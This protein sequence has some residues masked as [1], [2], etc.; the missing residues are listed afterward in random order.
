[1]RRGC[2]EAALRACALQDDDE[3]EDD[4][5]A[6]DDADLGAARAEVEER[7]HARMMQE[8]QAG[9]EMD[10]DALK[11]YVNQR[12]ASPGCAV[13]RRLAALSALWRP[14]S[15]LTLTTTLLRTL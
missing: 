14:H 3:D 10:E 11:E 6:I 13:S 12:C 4:R 15:L 5:E 2:A 1:M 7:M 8:R 9:N